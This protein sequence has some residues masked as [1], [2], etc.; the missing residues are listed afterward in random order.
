MAARGSWEGVGQGLLV[1]TVL[2]WAWGGYA[3]LTSV[4][5]PEE[6]A[7]RFAMFGAMAAFLVAALAIPDVFEET[8][9][10]FAVA[11]GVIRV[12]HLVLFGLASRESPDLRRSIW[13]ALVPGTVIGTALLV[14]ASQLDDTAQ[15]IVWLVALALDMGAPLVFGAAGWQLVPGHFA[16]RYGLI[17]LIALGES[18]VAIGIGAEGGLDGGMI[19]AAVVGLALAAAMWWAYFDV[20]ALAAERRLE[21]QPTGRVQNEMARDSYSFLHL[22]MVAGVVLVAYG[23]KKTLEHVGDPLETVPATALVG[24]VALYLLA[25]VAFRWRNMRTLNRQRLV[26]A[27]GLMALLPVAR[28]VDALVALAGVATLLWALIAY[29]VIVFREARDRIRHLDPE[30]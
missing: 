25:H 26:L 21:E 14:I 4:L 2:W 3:W 10:T 23:L 1:L 19:T 22:P 16:D 12:A 5:N 18:I 28:D 30:T 24:G 13:V 17:F 15:G 29:E 9:L 20:V 7:V 27:V 11:Y 6:G 8:G